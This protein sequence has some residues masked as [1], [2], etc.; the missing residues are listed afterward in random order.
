MIK[1]KLTKIKNYVLKDY[2]YDEVINITDISNDTSIICFDNEF[3]FNNSL[4]NK[5]LN[6]EFDKLIIISKQNLEK[7]YKNLIISK[8]IKR[9]F[10]KNIKGNLII[11]MKPSNTYS[12]AKLLIKN[13]IALQKICKIFNIN[14]NFTF[15]NKNMLGIILKNNSSY[16][17][18]FTTTL[19]ALNEETLEGM[20]SKIYNQVCD[21]LDDEF[22]RNNLCDFKNNQ[23]FA[24]REGTSA[25]STMGCCYTFKYSQ[26]P[27]A[28]E[29][30]TNV[31]QCQFLDCNRCSIKSI[32]C[33]LFT[34]KSLQKRGIK[35]DSHKILLLDCFFN[36]KQHLVL[37]KNFFKTKDEIINKLLENNHEPYFIYYLNGK[38]RIYTISPKNK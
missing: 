20:Y 3:N 9:N 8:F 24:N 19:L 33:K 37:N 38:Y 5:F 30:L 32:S 7:K 4:F 1:I 27:F 31:K 34:C 22:K 12:E 25:H 17:S 16:E 35:F 6:R 23:C 28:K 13:L 15:N 29:L 21:F 18:D 26:N 36:K 14:K 10:L 11:I 2:T